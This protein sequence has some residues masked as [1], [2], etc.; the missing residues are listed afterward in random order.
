M[1]ARE[2]EHP[3]GDVGQVLLL[4]LFLAV[5]IADSFFWHGST[6]LATHVPLA[7]RLV[8]LVLVVT[9]AAILVRSGHVVVDQGDRGLLKD[10][11]FRHVRH[12]LYLGSVLGYLGLA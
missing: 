2:G 12:P 11:A 9:V 8:L 5:W 7:L 1:K 4:V 3:R 10:G 6:S